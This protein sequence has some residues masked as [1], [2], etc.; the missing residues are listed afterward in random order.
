MVCFDFLKKNSSGKVLMIG[1][2]CGTLEYDGWY[3]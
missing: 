2:H 3:I 1:L